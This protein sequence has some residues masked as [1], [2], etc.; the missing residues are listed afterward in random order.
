M[1]DTTDDRMRKIMFSYAREF[2]FIAAL[3]LKEKQVMKPR[4]LATYLDCSPSRAGRI[5]MVL[6]WKRLNQANTH[7][8]NPTY[9]RPGS[10][11]L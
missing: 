11:L 3:Y 10:A 1:N 5:L 6:E 9:V 8:T 7:Y 2:L 4:K